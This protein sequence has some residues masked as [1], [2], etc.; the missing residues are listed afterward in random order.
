MTKKC[1]IRGYTAFGSLTPIKEGTPSGVRGRIT[2]ICRCVCGSEKTYIAEK[3]RS[4]VVTSCGCQNVPSRLKHGYTGT[5]TYT[6][7]QSM[8]KRCLKSTDKNYPKYSKLGVCQEWT[9]FEAFLAAVGE[10]PSMRHT[11]DRIDNSIG[12]FPGNVR[13]ALWEEQQRNR[14]NNRLILV[15]GPDGVCEAITMAEVVER[16]GL[17][18]AAVQQRLSKHKKPIKEALGSMYSWPDRVNPYTGEVDD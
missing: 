13:W 16:L 14:T 18:R 17:T 1:D 12:Y 6:T 15:T 10:R 9:V 11:L 7:W 3:L 5:P 8:L 2:Y 4:G